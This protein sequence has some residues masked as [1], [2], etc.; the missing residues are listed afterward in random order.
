MSLLN[1]IFYS[2]ITFLV[3]EIK[4]NEAVARSER[5]FFITPLAHIGPLEV[6]PLNVGG[7]GGAV[8]RRTILSIGTADPH[9]FSFS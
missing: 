7:K 6:S 1:Y 4:M 9:V 3:C 5:F 8:R 2:F